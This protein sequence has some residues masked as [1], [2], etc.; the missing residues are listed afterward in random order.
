M[1]TDS[2]RRLI[3]A[4]C[5]YYG[6]WVPGDPR[7]WRARGHKR[8]SSGDYQIP[9][10]A[11]QHAGLRRYVQSM[12][13]SEPAMLRPDEYPVVGS[14]FLLKL[15]KI[16]CAVRCLSCG[17]THLHVLY[18]SKEPDAMRELGRAKQYASLKLQDRPG[19]LWGGGAKIIPIRD[20]GHASGAF[21]YICDHALKEGAWVWRSDR[22]PQPTRSTLAQMT[23]EAAS[24]PPRRTSADEEDAG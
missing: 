23:V 5:T 2:H 7:G 3:H 16:G 13:A 6:Q 11:A 20:D 21:V 10:P 9:P 18:E 15:L 14:A 17:P 24:D 19:R 8:H 22:D 4:I 12:M 1:A